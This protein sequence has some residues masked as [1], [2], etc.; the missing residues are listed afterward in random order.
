MIQKIFK[1]SE[2]VYVYTYIKYTHVSKHD[3]YNY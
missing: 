3:I 1:E 2:Y